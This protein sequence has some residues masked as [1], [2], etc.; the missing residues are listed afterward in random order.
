M[1]SYEEKQEARRERLENAAAATRTAANMTYKRAREI[2][3]AIPFGQPIIVGHYN[4]GRDRNYRARIHNTFGRAFALNDRAEELARRAAS[5]G[6]SGDDPD[7][8][9]KLR[10]QLAQREAQQTR[11]VQVNKL[12]RAKNRDGLA[13]MG[14]VP[15][16]IEKLMTPD[17]VHGAG[18]P[19]Y[20]LSNNK[21]FE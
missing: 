14:Y 8:I 20:A 17:R 2:S 7:A 19:S 6:V 21:C 1:N 9:E 12:V 16:Q 18:Y 4:E 13:A 5:V 10:Q 15:D 3:S 11:M